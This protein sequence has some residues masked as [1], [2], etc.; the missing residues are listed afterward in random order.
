MVNPTCNRVISTTKSFQAKLFMTQDP[1]SSDG[2]DQQKETIL[3]NEL[4]WNPFLM[5]Y[6]T[7]IPP[8]PCPLKPC[9]CSRLPGV[10]LKLKYV[11]KEKFDRPDASWKKMFLA[12]PTRLVSRALVVSRT[13]TCAQY[14]DYISSKEGED[15]EILTMKFLMNIDE[16]CFVRGHQPLE[17]EIVLRVYPS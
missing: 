12:H 16:N 1:L 13:K 3:A 9:S 6:G 10:R 14:S 2:A 11:R 17:D 5:H 8:K 7:L 4:R 15:L